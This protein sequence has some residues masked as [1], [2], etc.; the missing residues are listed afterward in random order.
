M[1][2]I[3]HSVTG[4]N[5]GNRSFH[6][7]ELATAAAI[8]Q[9]RKCTKITIDICRHAG[10][11]EHDRTIIGWAFNGTVTNEA[12]LDTMISAGKRD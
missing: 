5:F 2:T 4:S 11:N 8:A 3:R 9:S 7:V 10:T 6:T 1:F 12:E